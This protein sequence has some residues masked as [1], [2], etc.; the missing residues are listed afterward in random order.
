[1]E[2]APGAEDIN[3]FSL[4]KD[5]YATL[6]D[7]QWSSSDESVATA[8]AGFIPQVCRVRG[9]GPGTAEITGA[10]RISLTSAAGRLVTLTDSITFQ[11]HVS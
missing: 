7:I 4:V 6:E 10:A 5:Y 2:L 8:E 9:H 11:V 3:I 1:M